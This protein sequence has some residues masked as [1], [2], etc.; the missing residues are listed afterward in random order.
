M[1][2][3]VMITEG[4]YAQQAPMFTNYS[5]AYAMTNP[6]FYGLSDGVNINSIYRDQYTGFKDYATGTRVSPRTFL[7]SADLPIPAALGG[8][9]LSI[10][11]DQLGFEDNIGV[12]LGYS[13]HLDLGAG[14]MG[15]GLA[16]NL[17]NRAVDFTLARPLVDSDQAIPN[18]K[19]TDMLFDANLGVF[20]MIPE[21]FYVAASVTSLLETKGKVLTGSATSSASFVGDRTFYLVAG[22]EYQFVNSLFKINPLMCLMSDIANTQFNVGLK[23]WYNDKFWVGLNYR[24]Q[25]SVAVMAGFS[26]KGLLLS[27]AYDINTMGIGL[28]GSHEVSLS[29][30]FKLNLDKSPRIYRSARYL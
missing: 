7:I 30:C 25:E 20:Y 13:Y 3:I 8:F 18:D 2:V 1:M 28:K 15:I 29:Y 23:G 24:Y 4:L 10:V 11:K 22:Y 21:T 14:T 27:Y 12:N 17:T 16:L 6:G 5:N 26:I 9:G 19:Q